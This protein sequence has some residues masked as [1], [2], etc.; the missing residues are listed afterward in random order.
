[1]A[2]CEF[3]QQAEATTSAPVPGEPLPARQACELCRARL[4]AMER[5][6]RVE[7]T[8]RDR[9]DACEAILAIV[10]VLQR[11]GLYPAC[12]GLEHDSLVGVVPANAKQ[13]YKIVSELFLLTGKQPKLVE[14]SFVVDQPE[15]PFYGLPQ[16]YPSLSIPAF[17]P[18]THGF[19]SGTIRIQ[20]T[21]EEVSRWKL[22]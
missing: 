20:L 19:W 2:N 11:K 15:H 4:S 22:S 16:A 17:L 18:L 21:R 7:D 6:R 14:A 12:I 1:M 10:G 3:C 13:T 9:K 5:V 8:L